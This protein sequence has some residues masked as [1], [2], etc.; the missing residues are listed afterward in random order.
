[1]GLLDMLKGVMRRG[2]KGGGGDLLINIAM[3]LV[4]NPN[5]GGLQGLVKLFQ[6]RGLGEQAASWVSTGSNLPISA[7]Q[8]KKVFGGGQLGQIASQL[9]VSE[10]EAAGGLADMM[11]KVIDKLTPNGQIPKGDLLAEGLNMLKGKL[12]G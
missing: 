12:F 6:D 4:S 3:Q 8:I 7:D 9:G 5:S 11:P 1:M 10:N 2:D